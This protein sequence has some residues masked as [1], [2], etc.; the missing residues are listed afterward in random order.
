MTLKVTD[1]ESLQSPPRDY[2][3]NCQTSAEMFHQGEAT[4]RI[5]YAWQITKNDSRLQSRVI[6][7]DPTQPGQPNYNPPVPIRHAFEANLTR[8]GY[9]L[10]QVGRPQLLLLGDELRALSAFCF[11]HYQP[12]R[13][14]SLYQNTDEASSQSAYSVE[15]LRRTRG[16]EGEPDL[17]ESLT[18]SD[19]TAP[20]G[21]A[22][23]SPGGGMFLLAASIA[24]SIVVA[25]WH[26]RKVS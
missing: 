19:T 7:Q 8:P 4:G 9:F 2:D 18:P 11:E 10:F 5:F 22:D 14:E 25:G 13:S 23:E 21:S 26:R 12:V 3:I 6:W 17:L 16:P 1:A 24:V 20:T 15:E